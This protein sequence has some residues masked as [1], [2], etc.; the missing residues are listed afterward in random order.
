[1]K[2]ERSILNVAVSIFFRIVLFLGSFL[3]RRYLI[4][5]VGNDVNGVHSLY[6]SVIGVL[7]VAELGIGDAIIFCMYKPIVEGDTAKVSVLYSLF[8]RVYTIIGVVIAVAGCAVMP[9]L[10][11]L[12]KGYASLDV[13]L[14]LTFGLMLISTVLTYFFSAKMSLLNAYRNNYI[15]TTIT[16][17]GQLLQ[18]VLQIIVLFRTQSFVWFLCCRI[19]AVL[20]QWILTD[21]VTSKKYASILKHIPV[22]IDTSTR[23]DILQNVKA[24]FMHRIGGVMVNTIDSIIISTFIGI[25]ILGKYSNYTTIMTAMTSVLILFFTPLTST[26]GHIFVES[27]DNTKQYFNFFY[28][29]NFSLGCV[30][31]LGYYSIIDELIYLLFGPDLELPKSV[32]FVITVNYFIQYMRQS[33][34]TFRDATGTFYYDRWKPIAEGTCNLVLSIFFVKVFQMALGDDFA[35][36]GVIAATIVTNILICHIVEPYVLFKHAFEMSPQRYYLQNYGSIVV[37]VALLF[38]VHFCMVTNDNKVVEI[39]INGTIAVGISLVPIIAAMMTNEDFRNYARRFG[40]G[41]CSKFHKT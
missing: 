35:V 19:V 26:I 30:F 40:G 17:I 41:L 37:F 39:F 38:A 28:A 7:S 8:Q 21:F 3:V 11:Y 14:Y 36:V 23:G 12:A 4:R 27:K 13:N 6:L 22:Q 2:K 18:Q 24:M 15:A 25:A 33:V 10:P 32:S 16:S 34:L 5:F 9:F 20:V 29:L 1:M 31:F